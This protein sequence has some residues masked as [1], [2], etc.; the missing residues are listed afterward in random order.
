ML[1]VPLS[2]PP[3]AKLASGK[4]LFLLNEAEWRLFFPAGFFLPGVECIDSRAERR[5]AGELLKDAAPEVVVTSWSSPCFPEPAPE[6]IPSLRYICHTSGSVRKL[7]P[8]TYLEAGIEVT[9]WGTLAADAVAEH[10]LLLV[11]AGLR[12]M[13]EWPPVIS[14][15]L[16]WQPSPI[17]TETL[18]GKRVGIHGFGNVAR[19]LVNLLSPFSVEVSAYSVGVPNSLFTAH[20]VHE[21]SSLE[22]LFSNNEIVVDCEALN[23]ETAGSVSRAVLALMPEGAL[24]VNVGRGAIV[25][26]VALAELALSGRLRAA[27]DVFEHDPIARNSP[28]HKV[29]G[30]VM[31]P[32][33]A[34]PTSDQLTRCGELAKRNVSAYFAG[35]PLSAR[36]TLDIYDRAT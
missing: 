4:V 5:P 32:H 14:G 19:A 8:R 10:A 27:L 22:E 23:P 25:D 28:L 21:C 36:V 34:G 15:E 18:F 3:P 1:S 24:F 26:E 11:L 12:K 31:S 35:Q 16:R 29:P 9:N 7:I 30:I 6:V 2:A 17:R 13:R 20:G 33:I